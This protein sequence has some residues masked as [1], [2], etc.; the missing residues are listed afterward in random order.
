MPP[1]PLQETYAKDNNTE[2]PSIILTDQL[3]LEDPESNTTGHNKEYYPTLPTVPRTLR[4]KHTPLETGIIL[5]TL[6]FFIASLDITTQEIAEY[7]AENY[8]KDLSD[9]LTAM[10]PRDALVAERDMARAMVI[11]GAPLEH[12]HSSTPT[13]TPMTTTG[14]PQAPPPSQ[15]LQEQLQATT[16]F[17]PAPMDHDHPIPQRRPGSDVLIAVRHLESAYANTSPHTSQIAEDLLKHRIF[18]DETTRLRPQLGATDRTRE[19]LL[20]WS[21]ARTRTSIILHRIRPE[22]HPQHTLPSRSEWMALPTFHQK[23]VIHY[24]HFSHYGIYPDFERHSVHQITKALQNAKDV[25]EPQN[26]ASA[27]NLHSVTMVHAPTRETHHKKEKPRHGR[28][29]EHEHGEPPRRPHQK[30]G[31]TRPSRTRAPPDASDH[32]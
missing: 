14:T 32:Q 9:T 10:A 4:I 1:R 20:N 7:Y 28:R 3:K 5:S 15:A 17:L 31:A 18:W 2:M 13:W 19:R 26:T 24:T 16:R 21:Y 27:A 25:N 11:P 22:D 8:G 29:H 12:L 30:P 6:N 23:E